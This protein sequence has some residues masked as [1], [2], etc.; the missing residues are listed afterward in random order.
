MSNNKDFVFNKE[1]WEI[2]LKNILSFK[3]DARKAHL[4]FA[5]YRNIDLI[6]DD[7]F[8]QSAVGIHIYFEAEPKII[9]IERPLRMR[10]HA[11]QI[12]FP[13]GKKDPEDKT[14]IETALRESKEEIGLY[15]NENHFIG[16]LSKVYI[17]VTNFMVHAYVFAHKIK[18]ELTPNPD[19]VNEVLDLD[20]SLLTN[21]STKSQT[22]IVLA[23]GLKIKNSPCFKIKDKIIWGATGVILNELKWRIMEFHQRAV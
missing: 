16:K 6:P 14:L 23:N 4:E 18:P 17:P 8:I 5:P 7:N 11:G 22:D 21:D 2:H 10:K 15:A 9:L 1:N 20:L 12:A 19:E 3:F 13:G